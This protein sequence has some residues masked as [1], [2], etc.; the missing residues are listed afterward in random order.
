MHMHDSCLTTLYTSTHFF[1][2]SGSHVLQNINRYVVQGPLFCR[3]II[4]KNNP[5]MF[6]QN[7][8][9]HNSTRKYYPLT[10]VRLISL[11]KYLYN[12][13]KPLENSL[14]LINYIP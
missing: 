14:T 2:K 6:N 5:T 12:K 3:I 4:S 11:L 8:Q 10:I 9:R 13:S 7:M 1:F